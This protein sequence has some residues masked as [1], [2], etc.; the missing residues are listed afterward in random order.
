MTRD[1]VEL[2]GRLVKIL[3]LA[4]HP[5]MDA[6]AIKLNSRLTYDEEKTAKI[7]AK[8]FELAQRLGETTLFALATELHE[9]TQ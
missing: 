9:T 2:A 3:R 5:G 7:W 8:A 6:V 1:Q 4:G